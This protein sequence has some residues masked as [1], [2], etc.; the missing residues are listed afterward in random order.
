MNLTAAMVVV[1]WIFY[2]FSSIPASCKPNKPKNFG[3]ADENL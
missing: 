2:G 1:A 3:N